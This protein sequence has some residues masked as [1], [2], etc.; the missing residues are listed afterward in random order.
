MFHADPNDPRKVIIK[1][2]TVIVP[3]RGDGNIDLNVDDPNLK[4]K[5][6][7]L[8]EGAT[9]KLSLDFY[10]QHEIVTGLKFMNFAKRAG[11]TVSKDTYVVG[12]YAPRKEPYHVGATSVL[13]RSLIPPVTLWDLLRLTLGFINFLLSLAAFSGLLI[14]RS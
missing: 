14:C 12:S 3:E 2:F 6:Y 10:V 7:T 5:P 4:Q 1:Q 9:Y 11:L 8:K 13:F